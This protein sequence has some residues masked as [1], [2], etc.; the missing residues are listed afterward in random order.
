[1]ARRL[2]Q[3]EEGIGQREQENC[4]RVIRKKKQQ[5]WQG[6]GRLGYGKQ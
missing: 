4:V 2:D 6:A 3:G 5:I 1:M